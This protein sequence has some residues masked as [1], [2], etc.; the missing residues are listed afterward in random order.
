[1]GHR[2]AVMT[3][4]LGGPLWSSLLGM[5]CFSH[6]QQRQ[7][8]VSAEICCI[9]GKKST[10]KNEQDSGFFVFLFFLLQIVKCINILWV[11]DQSIR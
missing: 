11:S 4:R 1:M 3:H 9:K 2:S 6:H 8:D 10:G 5:W 7:M